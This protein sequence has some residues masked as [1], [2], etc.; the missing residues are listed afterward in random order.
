MNTQNLA[1]LPNTK[2]PVKIFVIRPILPFNMEIS[3]VNSV[4]NKYAVH[5]D[6]G[7]S[8]CV[9]NK[10]HSIISWQWIY[11]FCHWICSNFRSLCMQCAM[12]MCSQ[13]F[14]QSVSFH[15][16]FWILAFPGLSYLLSTTVTP[17]RIQVFF[18][19]IYVICILQ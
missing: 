5:T 11:S 19:F 6:N 3:I 12:C 8:I 4:L 7:F 9:M 13:Y 2:I 18:C 17:I 14:H 10:Q 16:S 15:F 1:H